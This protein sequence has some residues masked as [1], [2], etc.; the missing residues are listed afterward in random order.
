MKK[1]SPEWQGML[2]ACTA[3]TIFGFSFMFSRLALQQATPMVML[4][5]RFFIAMLALNLML[6]AG[7]LGLP[8]C[9]GFRL[10][11]A[12]VT[13]R[14]WGLLLVMGLCEPVLYFIGESVGV[15]LTNASFSSVMIAVIPI[16]SVAAAALLLRER[17]TVAQ[18]I[19][20]LL[21]IV[22]VVVIS[23]VGAGQGT[24]TLLGLLGLVLAVVAGSLYTILS[25]RLSRYTP[26]ERTYVMFALGL[27][28]FLATALLQGN[29]AADFLAPWSR[30]DFG[31]AVLYLGCLSSVLAYYLMNFGLTVL[32]VAR[33][34][35]FINWTTVVSI[36]AGVVFLHESFTW[37]QVAGSV[38]ILLGL[39]GV[40]MFAPQP[41][42]K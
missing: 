13:A 16:V 7:A 22:G 36:V 31:L 39:W 3:S 14:E 12:Q 9:S 35:V 11:L 4:S 17:P 28:W 20:S 27:I 18:V 2:A 23:V 30:P 5:W 37:V 10:R 1:L 6:L 41:S 19:F 32:S 38:L 26:F 24:V 42:I 25:R 40:N 33:Y 21:S 15:K 29:R 8:G 34:T